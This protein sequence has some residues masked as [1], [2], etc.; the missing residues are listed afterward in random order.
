MLCGPLSIREIEFFCEKGF[1]VVPEAVQAEVA[2]GLADAMQLYVETTSSLRSTNLSA[3][4]NG[5]VNMYHHPLQWSLRQSPRIYS[6]FAQMLGDK[7]L[8]VSIDRGKLAPP[9]RDVGAPQN[10]FIHW[11]IDTTALPRPVPLQGL[12]A[13]T[14]TGYDQGGFQCVP[15]FPAEFADWAATQ[16]HGRDPY[17]PDLSNL[18]IIDVPLRAGDLLL[19]S[20]L[21]PHGN[22]VNRSSKPRL[23]QFV[24]MYPC[25]LF[26]EQVRL[27]R[28][29]MWRDQLPRDPGLSV[30]IRWPDAKL[31]DL[32]QRLL[33]AKIWSEP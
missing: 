10:G 2:V 17:R 28:L 15:G 7:N 14:D 3:R 11:D 5:V 8:W 6:V 4:L 18:N 16:P 33:G 13:L 9:T 26:G 1:L 21:L 31:T 12:V 19:W 25:R 22:S 30:N 23:V 32:G 29:E 20:A 24:R 27:K